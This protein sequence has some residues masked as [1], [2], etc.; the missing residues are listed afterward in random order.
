LRAR[1]IRRAVGERSPSSARV[2]LV[3][4][5]GAAARHRAR[6]ARQGRD[7]RDVPAA[8]GLG[9]GSRAPPRELFD[10][11]TGSRSARVD[12]TFSLSGPSPLVSP[13]RGEI[14]VVDQVYARG[15]RGERSDYVTI[16]DAKTLAVLGDVEIPPRS[17][18]IG[19]GYATAAVLDDERFLVVFNQ[20]PSNSVSIV[21][22]ESR[23]FVDEIVI[24]G[25]ALVYPTGGSRFGTLCGNGSALQVELDA[26]GQSSEGPR[27]ATSSSTW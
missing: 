13:K 16:Y 23:S 17:S 6:R 21:D 19:H 8:L 24:G 2:V 18:S 14:Y 25:C 7:P 20:D 5:T 10:G 27:A 11:D 26:T 15:H 3:S 1:A 22:L 9:A 12:G 4:A